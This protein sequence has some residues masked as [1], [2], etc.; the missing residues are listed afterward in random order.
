MA[1][2]SREQLMLIV[3]LQ[4]GKTFLSSPS[5][6]DEEFK[7]RE[8]PDFAEDLAA[9]TFA[10][11][12]TAGH[13]ALGG[14]HDGDAQTTLNAADLVAAKIDSAARTGDALQIAD[15]GLVVGAIR[16]INADDLHAVLFGR[17]VVRDVAFLFEDAGNLALELGGWDVEFLVARTDRVANAGQE[18]GYWI[19]EV[20]S[21]SFIPRSLT[22]VSRKNQRGCLFQVVHPDFCITS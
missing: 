4:P 14:G 15:D 11:G 16:K 21:F 13:D 10:A 12:L 1:C 17:L 7:V 2:E 20:H 6:D 18:V 22:S 19:S 3:P 5:R 8:L 9:D